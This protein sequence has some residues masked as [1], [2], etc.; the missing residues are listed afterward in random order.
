MTDVFNDEITWEVLLKFL[1]ILEWIVELSKWHAT[2]FKPAIH[3]LID[4]FVR[5]TINLKHDIIN[6]WTVI[7]V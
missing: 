2:S 1:L 7:I 6:P 5:D 3:Y 4:T